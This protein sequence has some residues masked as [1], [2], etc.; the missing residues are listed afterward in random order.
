MT[1]EVDHPG[2]EDTSIAH[3]T[4]SLA[5]AL[6]L[7]ERVAHFEHPPTIAELAAQAGLARP[8]TY[9]L[10]QTLVSEGYLQQSPL[11]G[12]LTIG[13]VVLPL[14]ASLL[15]Q[16]RLRLQALPQLHMVAQ[17]TGERVNLGILDRDCILILAGVEKPSLPTIY[18][19]FGRIVPAHCSALGKAV[20][21]HLPEDEVRRIIR[22][23]PMVRRT[24]KTIVELPALLEELAKVKANGYSTELAENSPTSCCVGV[25]VLDGHDRPVAAI[26]VSGRALEPLLDHMETIRRAAEV[27]SHMLLSGAASPDP[28]GGPV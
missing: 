12:R 22:A 1:T 4:G 20:L 10:V 23:R 7:L 25:P 8:T 21:A 27:L 2:V 19:R 18:S 3:A 26:S 9:R 11:H 5:K 13:H 16:S 17:H 6:R 14:A 15:D 24:P 28:G